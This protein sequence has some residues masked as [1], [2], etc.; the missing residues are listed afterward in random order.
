MYGCS[1]SIEYTAFIRNRFVFEI[2]CRKLIEIKIDLKKKIK[3]LVNFQKK[4]LDKPIKRHENRL[5]FQ[6]SS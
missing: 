2:D 1:K 3:A 4:S 6:S 5:K